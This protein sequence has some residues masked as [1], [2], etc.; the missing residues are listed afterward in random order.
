[1]TTT[2]PAGSRSTRAPFPE[3]GWPA[4]TMGFKAAPASC[5]A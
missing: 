5:R 3:A 1:M 2:A 4:M